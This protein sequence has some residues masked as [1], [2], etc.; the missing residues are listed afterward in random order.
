[1]YILYYYKILNEEI[2]LRGEIYTLYEYYVLGGKK[3][4]KDKLHK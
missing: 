3:K 2:I 1:M 4:K